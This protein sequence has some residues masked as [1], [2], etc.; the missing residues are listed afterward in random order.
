VAKDIDFT[1]T[2]IR[3]RWQAGRADALRVLRERPWE[4]EI[5]PLEGVS[6]H[7]VNRA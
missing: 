7:E 1:R 6:V 2:G 3:A 5:D 4:R